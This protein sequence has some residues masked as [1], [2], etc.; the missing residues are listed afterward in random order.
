MLLV[1]EP[2][3]APSLSF[4]FKTTAATEGSIRAV[5]F[6]LVSASSSPSSNGLGGGILSLGLETDLDRGAWTGGGAG[7]SCVQGPG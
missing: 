5:D 1:S 3:T 2:V 4:G 7:G 6:G